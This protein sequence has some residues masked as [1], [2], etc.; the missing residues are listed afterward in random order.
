[1]KNTLHL[2]LALLLV[3]L[4][5]LLGSCGGGGGS[6][7]PPPAPA[8]S[9]EYQSIKTFHFTWGDVEG[10]TEYRLLEDREGS[11][12]YEVVATYVADAT[13]GD[14]TVFLPGVVN[15]R[16]KLAACNSVGCSESAEVAVD[17]AELVAG[18][19]YFK[20]SNTETGDQFGW[21]VA[22]SADGNTLAVGARYEDSS[23]TGVGG[24]ESN[25]SAA[26][27]GAVYVFV[28]DDGGTWSQQAYVKASN[29]GAHDYFGTAVAL[30]ADGNTLAVGARYEDSNATGV[31]G[32]ES[33]NS[34]ADSGAVYVF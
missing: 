17:P 1:M 6:E 8:L 23:A 9:L 31:G 20:A 4:G 34:A 12:S 24:D 26:D 21:S 14:L 32:D 5:S 25:D 22:L 27:S 19:G 30:S 11:G 29:T 3:G 28:Q 13:N 16:Y 10:E 2:V 7:N 18:V 33:D 15:A